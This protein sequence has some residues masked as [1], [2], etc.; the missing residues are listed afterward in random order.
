MNSTVLYVE[1]EEDYQILVQRILGKKGFQV[2]VVS[3]GEEAIPALEALN[4]QLLIL[5]VNLPDANGYSLCRLLR[6][7]PAWASLPILLLTVRRRPEEWLLG[8]SAG[9]DD[10]VLKPLNPPE[11]EERVNACVA[12]YPR[13]SKRADLSDDAEYLLIQAA[14]AGNRA[15]F[16]VL[17]EKYRSRLMN[18]LRVAGRSELDV[19]DATASAF[20]KAYEQ[21]SQFRGQSSFYTWVYRIAFN[22]KPGRHYFEK[23]SIE[24]ISRRDANEAAALL[25]GPDVV[26][27]GLSQKG[28]HMQLTQAMARVPGIYRQVLKWHFVRGI[29]YTK[30]ADR[31]GVP[32]GTVMSRLFKGKELLRKSWVEMN[33]GPR[34]G[35][36]RVRSGRRHEPENSAGMPLKKAQN[37]SLT[38]MTGEV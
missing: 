26:A 36:R 4:P 33:N 21:L 24:E 18:S 30:M 10:Y 34:R 32:R 27:D 37:A 19:E 11:L 1:D 31:L 3:S 23:T 29:S 8:F 13:D 28:L 2:H 16:Q 25:K 14:A 9:A 12:L 7:H 22:E 38:R 20:A 6:N 5:D 15:A 35:K 17:V